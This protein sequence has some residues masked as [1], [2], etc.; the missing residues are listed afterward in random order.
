METDVDTLTA[1]RSRILDIRQEIAELD[2]RRAD[3]EG[4]YEKARYLHNLDILQTAYGESKEYPGEPC[5]SCVSFSVAVS[6]E[7]SGDIRFDHSFTLPSEIFSKIHL[8]EN[9]I[10]LVDVLESIADDRYKRSSDRKQI[11]ACLNEHRAD[12]EAIRRDD[13]RSAL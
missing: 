11:S 5:W 7:I 10:R 4:E 12:F 13:E 9:A 8:A 6:L 2:E 3:L 1:L